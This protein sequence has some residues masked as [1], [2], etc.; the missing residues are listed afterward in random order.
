[1]CDVKK[2][3]CDIFCFVVVVISRSV[4]AL[5][6]PAE[7]Q[8]PSS[9]RANFLPSV[10]NRLHL[11]NTIFYHGAKSESTLKELSKIIAIV[12]VCGRH[13][14]DDEKFDPMLNAPVM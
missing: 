9:P 4:V 13:T 11:L 6:Q 7:C 12:F 1:M 14:T 5:S 2:S 3:G 8:F 10:L